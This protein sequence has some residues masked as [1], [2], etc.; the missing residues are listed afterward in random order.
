MSK[1]M[2]RYCR[3]LCDS[4]IP[5]EISS[6]SLYTETAY[7]HITQPQSFVDNLLT[8]NTRSFGKSGLLLNIASY[9][10]TI[11]PYYF[12]VNQMIEYLLQRFAPTFFT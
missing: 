3:V 9:P 6:K 12:I 7:K 5:F 4:M 2:R 10:T 1:I 11:P 8:Q